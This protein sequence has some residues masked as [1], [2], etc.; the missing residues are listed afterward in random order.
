MLELRSATAEDT[1]AI[2]HALAAAYRA[3]DTTILTGELGAG[4]TTLVRGVAEGLGSQDPVASPTFTL[5]REYGVLLPVAAVLVTIVPA[6]LGLWVGWKVMGLPAPLVA[7]AVAGQQCS[8]PAVTGVQK[9][10]G[11]TTPLLSYTIVYAF[12]SVVLP[13]LG[14]LVVV[15]AEALR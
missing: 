4:K 10:A 5:I 9:E 13:L 7:G 11:N 6:L 2:G 14:P 8:T 15:L 3:G 12:S 1:R